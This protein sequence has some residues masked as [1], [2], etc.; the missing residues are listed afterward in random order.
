MK[1]WL[2]ALLFAIFTFGADFAT[3]HSLEFKRIYF[4]EGRPKKTESSNDLSVILDRQQMENLQQIL[5]ALK[6][7]SDLGV[8]VLGFADKDECDASE[9][10]DLSSR[11]AR[12]IFDWLL[13]H[14]LPAKQIKGPE[15]LSTNWPLYD[16]ATNE[17]R[18]FNRRVD[19]EPF[20]IPE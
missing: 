11:R 20:T 9:C 6:E 2:S 19:F 14:G 1:T 18:R 15:G 13:R 12:A 5:S 3:S 10:S 4:A 7:R 8:K 17:E 16:G